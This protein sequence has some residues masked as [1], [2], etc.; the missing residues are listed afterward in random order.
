MT[1]QERQLLSPAQIEKIKED[2]KRADQKRLEN[3]RKGLGLEPQR[4]TLDVTPK[5]VAARKAA[6]AAEEAKIAAET[7]AI[8][9][10]LGPGTPS[11]VEETEAPAEV[12]KSKGKKASIIA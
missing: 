5:G 1:V 4:L 2:A 12:K 8:K 10:D 9:E 6:I 3:M 11:F 7:L